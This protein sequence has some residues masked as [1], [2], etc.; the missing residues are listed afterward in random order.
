[1]CTRPPCP[2]PNEVFV[3]SRIPLDLRYLLRS[4]FMLVF[5][6]VGRTVLSA[7]EGWRWFGEGF[8]RRLSGGVQHLDSSPTLLVVVLSPT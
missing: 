5:R 3:G 2:G 8:R 7:D 6:S 1:M 4:R